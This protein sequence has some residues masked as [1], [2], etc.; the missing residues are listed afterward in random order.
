M[1]TDENA[2]K[3]V[4]WDDDHNPSDDDDEFGM[5]LRPVSGAIS[6][7]DMELLTLAA[8]AI[9]AIQVE[10]IEGEQ[11]VNL[12]MA[13]GSVVYAWNPLI[14]SDDALE[15]AVR[16]HIVIA[17][18]A[19]VP[20]EGRRP[21]TAAYTFANAARADVSHE[22]SPMA[23]TRRAITSAAAEIGKASK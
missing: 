14:H 17:P 23:A 20:H 15:L 4:S 21:F 16:L 1:S 5:P 19:G 7:E 2:F 18:I 12:H 11:W 3:R 6:P 13:D 9:G 8:R 22:E 10:P